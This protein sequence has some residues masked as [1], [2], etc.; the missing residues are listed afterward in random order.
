M[1]RRAPAARVVSALLSRYEIFM[2]TKLN[3][4]GPAHLLT[5]TA[6]SLLKEEKVTVKEAELAELAG[7]TTSLWE[8]GPAY[9]FANPREYFSAQ[10][11]E[12]Q[13]AI[14]EAAYAAAR[15]NVSRGF[16]ELYTA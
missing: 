10:M 5:D 12:A 11:S 16:A 14:F 4:Q 9:A 8:R 7:V 2:V 6:R 1:K 13:L 15:P 3:G